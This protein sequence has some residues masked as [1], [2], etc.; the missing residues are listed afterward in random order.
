MNMR[1]I[2]FAIHTYTEVARWECY[3]GDWITIAGLPNLYYWQASN[4]LPARRL[5]MN[6][7]L[8]TFQ[9]EKRDASELVEL[10]RIL[11]RA[12]N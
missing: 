9:Q 6:C 4:L 7:N 2:R 11:Y 12:G 10:Y 1:N 3:P 5:S 8:R